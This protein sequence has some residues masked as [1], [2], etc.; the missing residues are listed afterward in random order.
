MPGAE[1][2][3]AAITKRKMNI[4]VLLFI[5]LKGTTTSQDLSSRLYLEVN[6]SPLWTHR[7][8]DWSFSYASFYFR[9]H[10]VNKLHEPRPTVPQNSRSKER[11]QIK[12]EHKK[13]LWREVLLLCH[14]FSDKFSRTD[15]NDQQ[16]PIDTGCRSVW[17]CREIIKNSTQ[18]YRKKAG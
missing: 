1:V 17:G 18:V 5:V 14:V 10:G 6:N 9:C 13:T 4:V 12:R 11:V 3:V 8:P 2:N 16:S 7:Q 15:S